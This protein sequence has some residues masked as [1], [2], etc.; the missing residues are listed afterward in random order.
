MK[1]TLFLMLALS[2]FGVLRAAPLTLEQARQS[3]L[4]QNT[5]IISARKDL[6]IARA[7]V[8]QTYGMFDFKLDGSL[9]FS[10][11][12]TEAVSPFT[13]NKTEVMAYSLGLSEKTLLGGTASL[14]LNSS[15]TDFFYPDL[16]SLSISGLDPTLFTG[17]L[18]PTY[19][20]TLSLSYTQPLLRNFWGR[21]DRI[22][23]ELAAVSITLAREGLKQQAVEQTA[24]LTGAYLAVYQA[25]NTLAIQQ[26][27]L[28]DAEAYYQ[29]ALRLKKLGLREDRDIFQTH[30]SVLKAQAGMRDLTDGVNQAKELFY[31]L[32]GYKAGVWKSLELAPQALFDGFVLPPAL[33][34]QQEDTLVNR[35]PA[36]LSGSLQLTI[37]QLNKKIA[38]NAT[39]P[40]L[41]LFALYGLEGVDEDWSDSYSEMA[42]NRYGEYRLG[43]NFSMALPNRSARGDRSIK[44]DKLAQAEASLENLKTNARLTIRYA[45]KKMAA[46]RE[47][48]DLSTQARVLLGQTLE[49]QHEYFGQGRITTRELLGAQSEYQGARLEELSAQVAWM[50]AVN[51]WKK[52]TGAYDHYAA[53]LIK[54]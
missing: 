47:K 1:P 54:E 17:T 33:T 45:Y 14:K 27:S 22:A 30:A 5:T 19:N 10:S 8:E 46:A 24:T 9:N 20:P 2:C 41:S 42:S 25:Q 51:D 11:S 37:A 12:R 39:L 23:L 43:V 52:L 44:A 26:A 53:A 18:N 32:A 50:K 6:A 34:P 36:V 48:Y 38:D 3:A 7:R 13:P 21:P 28:Q 40:S 15:K 31:H 35:Q 49:I 4:E 29:Q 16:A